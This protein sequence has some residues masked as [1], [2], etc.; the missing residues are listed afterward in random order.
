MGQA[1]NSPTHKAIITPALG[2]LQAFLERS[3]EKMAKMKNL[4]GQRF[5]RLVAREPV[6][7][8]Q[9]GRVLWLCDCDC[10]L[11]AVVSSDC[12]VKGTTLS[13]GCLN[14]ENHILRPNRTTHGQWGT[15]LY[16]IWK[17]M[18][19][20]CHNPNDPDYQ[21]YYGSRGITVCAEW[22]N[23][24]QAFHDWAIGAGYA[25]TLSL[26]RIDNDKGYSPENCRWATAKEQRHN[27]RR[28][29]GGSH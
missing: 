1:H 10:G 14:H 13:C 15:R 22:R 11:D 18:K 17:K 3:G 23:S 8:N 25:D 16:R 9:Q 19:S 5:G 26:D 29:G 24:F 20:R 2:F 27:Q 12:L 6:A 4:R 28:E 7:K 21:K